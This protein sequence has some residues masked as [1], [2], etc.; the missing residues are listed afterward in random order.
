MISTE[1]IKRIA[2]DIHEAIDILTAEEE[3]EAVAILQ[4]C[5]RDFREFLGMKKD[6]EEI[7]LS[8][9]TVCIIR[10]PIHR[11][12]KTEVGNIASFIIPSLDKIIF[13]LSGDYSQAWHDLEER[14][15]GDTE[16][17]ESSVKQ[18]FNSI[19]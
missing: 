13:R 15:R 4:N 14:W 18:G 17:I 19:P 11:L 6:M 1:N 5:L 2:E 7:Q 9:L 16:L 8:L 3:Y 12:L 10:Y